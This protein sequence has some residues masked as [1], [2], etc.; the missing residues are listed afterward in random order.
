VAI[1]A[2][3]HLRCEAILEAAHRN[4]TYTEEELAFALITENVGLQGAFLRVA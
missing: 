2:I 3:K 4:N 1:Y